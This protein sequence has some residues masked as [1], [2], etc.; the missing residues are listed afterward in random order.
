MTT[1]QIIWRCI[2]H[3][4]RNYNGRWPDDDW[5]DI[6]PGFDANIWLDSF[7]NNPRITLYRVENM[8]VVTDSG[9]NIL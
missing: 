4:A 6:S 1:Q 7:D 8:C 2:K 9:I 5:V 3:V